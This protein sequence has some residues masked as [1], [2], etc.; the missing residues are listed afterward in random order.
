MVNTVTSKQIAKTKGHTKDYFFESV[1]IDAKPRL[2][3]YDKSTKQISILESIENDD[4]V[5]IPLKEFQCGYRPY[6]FSQS[7]IDN[8]LNRVITKEEL[9]D[10][11]KVLVDKYIVADDIAKYLIQIDIMLSYCQEWITTL[12]FPYSVG[13][14]ESGKSTILHIA[15]W[16]CYRCHLGEDIPMADIYNFLGKDEEACGTIAEDEAQGLDPRDEKMRMYK[17]SYSKGSTKARIL[18]ADT[19]GKQQVFYKTF[20]PKWFAGE[21]IPTDKGFVERLAV[22]HMISGVPESN[23]KRPSKDEMKELNNLRNKLLVWKLQNIETKFSNIDSNFKNRDAELW[24]DFLCV[25]YN[26][27]YFKN[28]KQVAEN[29][30]TQR[31]DGI[32]NSFEARLFKII[33]TCLDDNLEVKALTLWNK[34]TKN[35]SE[36]SG[37]L[38][39]KTR[40]AFY[41]DEFGVK[42]TLN[43]LSRMLEHTFHSKKKIRN[44]KKD[45]KWSKVTS[46]SFTKEIIDAFVYKYGITLET[47][48]CV[49]S[50]PSG[51]GSQMLSLQ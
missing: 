8:L 2:L 25:A 27:K 28:A 26:T 11:I 49:Y 40:K 34:I 12:H 46:Y 14:T 35:N 21:K 1:M 44:I 20:C 48:M 30:V 4:N 17:S 45:T 31:Q 3:T 38:D 29:Y 50:G 19:S 18:G 51:Q 39:E 42:L 6:S 24:D 15:S 32:R 5:I 9:L 41:P 47:T 37:T 10:T 16:I 13:D 7:E 43:S 22:I 33:L 23:I 36:L